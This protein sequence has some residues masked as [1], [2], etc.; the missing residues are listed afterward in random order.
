MANRY[1]WNLPGGVRM[2]VTSG[3]GR[4]LAAGEGA[5]ALDHRPR[6]VDARHVGAATGGAARRVPQCER[7]TEAGAALPAPETLGLSRSTPS[8]SVGS[9]WTGRCEK[10]GRRE[11]KELTGLACFARLGPAF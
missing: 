3:A 6:R 11:L 8:A 9:R 7:A 1:K 5:L 4:D 10:T 2:A